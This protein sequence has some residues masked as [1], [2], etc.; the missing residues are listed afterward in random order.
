MKRFWGNV[1]CV[2]FVGCLISTVVTGCSLLDS[3]AG[4][5]SRDELALATNELQAASDALKA[6]RIRIEQARLAAV[7]QNNPQGVA[8][9]DAQLKAVNK[10]QQV[11]DLAAAAAKAAEGDPDATGLIVNAAGAALGPWGIVGAAVVGGVLREWQNR[12]RITAEAE[13]AAK[14]SAAA[15]SIVNAIDVVRADAVVGPS[16]KAAMA[17]QKELIY[18][19]LTPEAVSLIAGERI[20]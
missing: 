10:A 1:L 14:A 7:A 20:T 19:Q 4:D 2:V 16:M 5:A 13:A 15:K 9:A 17:S 18:K 3:T 12:K 8:D 6:E 11:A